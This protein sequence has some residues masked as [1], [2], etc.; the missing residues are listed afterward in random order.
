MRLDMC[1]AMYCAEQ[2]CLVPENTP[3]TPRCQAWLAQPL[4]LRSSA[5]WL[6]LPVHNRGRWDS[7]CSVCMQCGQKLP[8]SSRSLHPAQQCPCRMRGELCSPSSLPQTFH[9]V[10]QLLWWRENP[11]ILSSLA[12]KIE[13]VWGSN[14]KWEVSSIQPFP[15]RKS[16]RITRNVKSPCGDSRSDPSIL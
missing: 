5:L 6:H 2:L 9:Q 15:F 7:G 8:R 16:L 1:C 11:S 14:S 13:R 12:V 10:V 4:G 3:C